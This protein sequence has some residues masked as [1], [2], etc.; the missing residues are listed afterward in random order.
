MAKLSVVQESKDEAVTTSVPW[1]EV[2]CG[3]D[4]HF[5]AVQAGV[6]TTE[7]WE[8]ADVLIDVVQALLLESR[9]DDEND[10]NVQLTYA[11]S[12]LLEA[13]RALHLAVA[14]GDGRYKKQ[15]APA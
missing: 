15:G 11:A 9:R 8:E 12:F 6:N 5:F 2:R 4:K 3:S 1:E 14:E 13:A 7:A 10:R